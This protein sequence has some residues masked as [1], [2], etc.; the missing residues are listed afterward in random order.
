M[1][2][3][4]NALWR[5]RLLGTAVLWFVVVSTLG[6]AGLQPSVLVMAAIVLAVA[7]TI[8]LTL[9]LADLAD[10]IDRRPSGEVAST[11][12]GSDSR[13]RAVRRQL[14][15]QL[16]FGADARLHAHLVE[17]LD[18]RLESTYGIRRTDDPARA[19]AMLGPELM[20]FVGATPIDAGL[21]D[22]HH[23]AAVITR[24]E[25]IGASTP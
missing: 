6:L 15:D 14:G 3:R 24:I 16:R 12:F 10:P 17:L 23:L 21:A 11:A 2:A 1:T 5:R 7:G 8:W 9:D 22:P 25:S 4:S 13:V 18:E 20:A 19:A